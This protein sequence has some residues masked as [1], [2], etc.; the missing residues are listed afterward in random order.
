MSLTS[1]PAAATQSEF[2]ALVAIDWADQKHAWKMLVPG[3]GSIEQGQLDSRPEAVQAWASA[4][5]T[6]FDSRPVA[7]C[8]EQKHGA[9]VCQLSAFL[10]L[11]LFLIPTTTIARYRDAFY[12]SG[13]KSDPTD[14]SLLLELLIQHRHHLRQ[15]RPETAET[16]LLQSLVQMRRGL[17]DEKTRQSN[18]LTAQL[19]IH[20]PQALDWLD[21]IDSPMGCDLLE[22]WPTLDELKG[23][24]PVKLR[25]FFLQHHS[26][27]EQR[28]HERIQAIY[29][30]V[31]PT[32]DPA[33]VTSARINTK[34]LVATLKQLN[35]SLL[36]LE[37]KIEQAA[38]AHPEAYLFEGLP[39]AG[40][41]LKPRLIAAFGTQRDRY[42]TAEELQNYCGI[43]PV[44]KTSGKSRV[45]SLRWACPQFLRQTFHEFAGCSRIKCG[46]AQAFY[47]LQRS[48][49]KNH[50]AAIRTL[51]FKWLRILFRCWQNREPYN[52]ARYLASLQKHQS[53]LARALGGDAGSAP[54]NWNA[55]SGFQKFSFKKA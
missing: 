52:E 53:P 38:A 23:V 9:L 8:L 42:R 7:I 10:H 36:E 31:V 26:R 48:R 43:S 12:P 24:N 15:I 20:F 49:G 22:N 54:D 29:Q 11:I 50:H 25:R 4:L 13:A 6:R 28:I 46:W 16:R 37:E 51:A 2:A 19:K 55:V 18:R 33:I 39:G 32:R 1:T 40:R 44:I 30:A 45:V 21:D 17:V 47:Q 27:S 5:D 35:R 41:A 34:A 14:T 3:T